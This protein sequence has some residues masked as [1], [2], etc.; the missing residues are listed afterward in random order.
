MLLQLNLTSLL[1]ALHFAQHHIFGHFT[2]VAKAQDKAE[3]AFYKISDEILAFSDP[4]VRKRL[5]A[6]L[7]SIE[8]Q[9]SGVVTDNIRKNEAKLERKILKIWERETSPEE[10]M[11]V[12]T[13]QPV[14]SVPATSADAPGKK[15]KPIDPLVGQDLI[16][17]LTDLVQK[18]VAKQRGPK[19]LQPSANGKG[20]RPRKG[21]S[22]QN[23][24]NM[25]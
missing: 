7:D 25:H 4:E 8:I 15:K 19:R 13:Q 17:I 22:K 23:Q 24:R 18:A 16:K 1:T 21:P 12:T 20:K 14:A 2:V 3:N 11:E 10:P 5:Q 9:V 6:K